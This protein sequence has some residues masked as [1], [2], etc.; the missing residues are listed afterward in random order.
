MWRLDKEDAMG[1]KAGLLLGFGAGYVL[2][3]KA[4]RQRYEDIQRTWR[5]VSGSPA[6]QRAAG[7]TAEVAGDRGK[8]ALSVVQKGVEKA[9][10]AVKD[11]INKNASSDTDPWR[12]NEVPETAEG[13]LP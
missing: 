3:A 9:G 2:G 7:K 11:R 6:V 10:S 1:T 4:G 8:Q 5:Q 12:G 13:Q